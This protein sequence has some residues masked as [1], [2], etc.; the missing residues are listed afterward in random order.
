[1]LYI[2]LGA[3]SR[4]LPFNVANN[5][6]HMLPVVVTQVIL[7]GALDLDDLMAGLVSFRLAPSA[8]GPNT[9]GLFRL[10]PFRQFLWRHIDEV[11]P[12]LPNLVTGFAANAMLLLSLK[13]QHPHTA[14]V[15]VTTGPGAVPHLAAH[16]LRHSQPPA[17]S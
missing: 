17:M 3:T 13:E 2:I 7:N 8:A 10:Q 1:M 9:L 11:A 4:P 6:R 12:L 5:L 15:P 14:R 16:W